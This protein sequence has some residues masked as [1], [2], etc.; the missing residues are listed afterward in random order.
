MALVQNYLTT[1]Y[2]HIMECELLSFKNGLLEEA[3]KALVAYL[4]RVKRDP[5]S[6]ESFETFQKVSPPLFITIPMNIR[7]RGNLKEKYL[8]IGSR[9]GITSFVCRFGRGVSK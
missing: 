5:L 2:P 7:I 9:H 1:K 8:F 4:Q 6:V 3:K